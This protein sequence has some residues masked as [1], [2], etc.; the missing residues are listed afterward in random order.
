MVRF[1]VLIALLIQ[2]ALSYTQTDSLVVVETGKVNCPGDC[3]LHILAGAAAAIG[4]SSVVYLTV[5]Q[6]SLV[7]RAASAIAAGVAAA[8]FFGAAK[9]L[10]DSMHPDRNTA[11]WRDFWNTIAGGSAGAVV[12]WAFYAALK[13]PLIASV[14][15]LAGIIVTGYRPVKAI[16]KM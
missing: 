1:L 7:A 12:T 15:A 11:E 13:S 4:T 9:E 10:F 2:S 6:L 3:Q 8:A 16:L 14:V 5:G